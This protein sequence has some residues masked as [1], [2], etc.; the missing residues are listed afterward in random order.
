LLVNE[1]ATAS[2]RRPPVDESERVKGLKT[3]VWGWFLIAIGGLFLLDRFHVL[4]LPNIGLM[5]PLS[6]VAVA[7]IHVVEGR[8]GSALMF[9]VMGAWF[10]ACTLEWHG[11]TYSN[12]WP[13]LL[14][15]V[16]LGIVLRALTGED[17]R[18]RRRLSERR[19]ERRRRREERD[20]V[21]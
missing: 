7:A 20:H 12:S 21:A 9:L 15:A 13:I 5:W 8:I 18:L 2:E 14:I 19:E 11:I 16:G 10:Q 3:M 17:E 1:A 4:N 6:F